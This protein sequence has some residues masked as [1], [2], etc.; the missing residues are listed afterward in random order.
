MT[1]KQQILSQ[2]IILFADQ[3]YAGVS[4]RDLARSTGLGVSTLYHHFPDK[5]NLY[6]QTVQQ[7]FANKADGF[8]AVWQSNISAQQRLEQFVERLTEMMLADKNFHR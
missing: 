1:S 4:M 8:T 7:A 5:Q 3:G 6:L 2:A